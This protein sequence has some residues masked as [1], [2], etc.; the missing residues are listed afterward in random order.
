MNGKKILKIVLIVILVLV[1]LFLANIIR[2]V[3]ILRDLEDKIS[4][5]DLKNNY[6]IIATSEQDNGQKTKMNFY[7]KDNKELSVLETEVNGNNAKISWYNN[8]ERID[9]FY[10]GV[11]YKRVE[12]DA[13]FMPKLETYNIFES[14]FGG[15]KNIFI[16]SM[17]LKISST[18]IDDNECYLIKLGTDKYYV[19]KDTGLVINIVAYGMRASKTYEFDNVADEIF[20]EPDISQYTLVKN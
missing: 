19:E 8:G 3:I 20:I 14:T 7:K 2:K 9:T 11:D 1:V 10:E 4:K 6:N 13:S 16:K 18:K 12:I 17:T 5:Y 15:D